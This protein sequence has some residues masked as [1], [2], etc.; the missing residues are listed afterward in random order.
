MMV[1]TK[2]KSTSQVEV[3]DALLSIATSSLQ[4]SLNLKAD[5]SN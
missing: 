2:E 4:A 1:P 3:L 5:F